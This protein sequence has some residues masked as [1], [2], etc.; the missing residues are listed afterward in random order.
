MTADSIQPPKTSDPVF[1]NSLRESIFLLLLWLACCL[2]TVTYCYLAGYL[3][4][5]PHP[6]ATGP[7]IGNLVGPLTAFDRYPQSLTTP[8][9]LGVPDWVFFGVITPWVVAVAIT[10]LYCLYFFVEDDLSPSKAGRD[11]PEKAHD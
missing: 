3:V 5:E 9:G 8:L 4:H 2:Y 1:R 7:S 6:N 10:V 11:Q